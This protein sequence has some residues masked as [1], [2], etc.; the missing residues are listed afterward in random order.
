MKSKWSS[1]RKKK[2]SGK[3]RLNSSPLSERKWQG[4]L[5]KQWLKLERQRKN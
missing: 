4:Q 2:T 1:L 3:R 5:L